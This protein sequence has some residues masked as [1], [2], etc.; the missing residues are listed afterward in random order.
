MNKLT[1]SILSLAAFTSV[2]FANDVPMYDNNYTATTKEIMMLSQLLP[3][4]KKLSIDVSG[5]IIGKRSFFD[6][7]SEN[8]DPKWRGYVNIVADVDTCYSEENTLSLIKDGYVFKSRTA[9]STVVAYREAVK[10]LKENGAKYVF[11]QNA[12]INRDSEAAVKRSAPMPFPKYRDMMMGRN[13]TFTEAEL[14]RD[15][16]EI[17]KKWNDKWKDVKFAKRDDSPD[18][19]QTNKP[20]SEYFQG[21]LTDNRA[22]EKNNNK[23]LPE[24]CFGDHSLKTSDFFW[25]AGQVAS[26]ALGARGAS[27]GNTGM[28][29]LAAN[30]SIAVNNTANLQD[31]STKVDSKQLAGIALQSKVSLTGVIDPQYFSNNIFYKESKLSGMLFPIAEVEEHLSHYKVIPYNVKKITSN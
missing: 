31:G 6:S 11:V 14:K 19:I 29:S 17:V 27:T 2:S 13:P 3:E 15:H 12:L 7:F 30:S 28:T 9:D 8:N 24:M 16:D 20:F 21:V 1:S 4:G 22:F 26:L 23:S 25:L 10:I 18:D 5:K